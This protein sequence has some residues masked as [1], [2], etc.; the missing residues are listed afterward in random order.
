MNIRALQIFK[1]V[2]EEMSFTKAA[3]KLYMTQPAVSHAI[4]DL[5]MEKNMILL[6]R[7][8]KKIYLTEIGKKFLD[9]TIQ[10]L[11]LYD[12]LDNNFFLSMEES[13]IFIGSCI[14]IGNFWLPNIIKDFKKSHKNTPVEVIID[15]A[16]EI[17]Q[18]VLSNKIDVAL[19]EGP[20]KNQYL[21]KFLFSSYK[22]SVV[23]STKHHLALKDSITI[24]EFINENLI[25]R[26]K[27][28]AIRDCLDT[29]LAKEDINIY[30]QW[31]SI[32]SQAIIES[33]SNN[34]GIT[35]LPDVLVKKQAKNK[36]LKLLSIDKIKLKNNNY[37]VYHKNKI[38]S[39]SMIDFIQTINNIKIS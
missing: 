11:N 22:L 2:C 31:T 24:N 16:I 36:Q 30:P 4:K 13:P 12:N 21:K 9:K 17:E 38:L 33:V 15:R 3:E 35:I 8:G 10:I 25:L 19:I 29:T 5:E 28:S 34:L 14:T 27:G 6:E 1:K 7:I 26:E 32:N 37:I 23:C 20:V 18:L 39:K